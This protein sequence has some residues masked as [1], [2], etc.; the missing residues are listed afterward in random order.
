MTAPR[1]A[2]TLTSANSSADS[3]LDLL[4]ALL[5]HS[6][7]EKLAHMESQLA[8]LD[9]RT[10]DKDALVAMLAPVIGDALK[11]KI[12]ESRQEMI[13]ALYPIIGQLV[14]RAVSEAMREFARSIDAQMRRSLNV[15]QMWEQWRASLRGVS[16]TEL[17]MRQALPFEVEQVFMIHRETG[18]LLAHRSR[19]PENAADTE[20]ISG[21][22]TAIRDFAAHALRNQANTELDEIQ[23]G[24]FRI[25][26]EAV[27]YMYLAVVLHGIEPPGFRAALRAQVME[28][29]HQY[30]AN[31]KY[32]DGDV[33]AFHGA[34]L[35]LHSILRANA[36]RPLTVPR[37]DSE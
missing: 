34:G 5:L 7:Q 22:L 23:Y 2:S 29:A 8:E 32:F 12:R 26:I 36:G 6:E 4:R 27:Q 24:D 14:V 25:V 11:T 16:K 30:G 13:E 35:Q 10:R 1:P 18:L 21:M 3:D 17:V 31:L 15:R 9:A 37:G 28:L 33:A 19:I 20:S